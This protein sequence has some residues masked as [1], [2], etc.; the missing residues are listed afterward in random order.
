MRVM[1]PVMIK[2]GEIDMK[3]VLRR[4][5]SALCILALAVSV[6]SGYRENTVTAKSSRISVTKFYSL[7]AQSLGIDEAELVEKSGIVPAD[8]N[9]TNEMAAVIAQTADEM[10]NGDTY[11]KKR[12]NKVVDLKRISDISFATN[13]YRTAIYKVFTKGIMIGKGNGKCTQ[14]RSFKPYASITQAQAE[15]VIKRVKNK[16]ARFKLS[17]DGQVI[18]TTNL[19]KRKKR[20]NYIL[21]SFPN[22]YYNAPMTY[23]NIVEGT[24]KQGEDY[25]WVSKFDTMTRTS[26]ETQSGKITMS[27]YMDKY[28]QKFADLIRENLEARLSYNYKTSGNKWFNKLRKTYYISGDASYDS[29][30][31]KSIRSYMKKAKKNKLQIE[32]QQI[33]VEPSAVY[34]GE[35]CKMFRCYVK[36]RC[37]ADKWYTANS[38]KQN[39]LIF[40]DYTYITGMKN[41]KWCEAYIDIGVGTPAYGMADGTEVVTYDY[42]IRAAKHK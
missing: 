41:G 19:P 18:R 3:N 10:A 12:Y 37:K 29:K 26:T 21:A 27:D 4:M 17:P 1:K 5:C 15:A 39:E 16:T 35:G 30:I 8:S 34:Y 25:Q 32:Y 40:S 28:G 2:K 24:V 42:F 31:S 23:E 33:T 20:Y 14:D 13:D 6:L 36:F 9:L 11:S 22:S 7:M 38:W